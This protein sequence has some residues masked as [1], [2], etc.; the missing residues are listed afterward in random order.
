MFSAGA[1]LTLVKMDLYLKSYCMYYKLKDSKGM[2][3]VDNHNLI[4]AFKNRIMVWLPV[5]ASQISSAPLSA[6]VTSGVLW[7]AS[8]SAVPR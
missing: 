1:R 8:G 2:L 3:R 7:D 6:A 4:I 5:S